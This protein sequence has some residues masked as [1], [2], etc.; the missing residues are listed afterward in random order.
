MERGILSTGVILLAVLAGCREQAAEVEVTSTREVTSSDRVP[1][2][3]ATSRE[4]FTGRAQAAG[5]G[6]DI[7]AVAGGVGTKPGFKF[8]AQE[9]WQ[10]RPGTQFRRLNFAVGADGAGE[11][12]VSQSRGGL[13]GNIGRWL[14]QFGQAGATEADVSA[15]PKVMVMGGEGILVEAAGTY[16]PG[17]GR[18][19]AEG[20]ALLGVIGMV[21]GGV[22]T[23]KMTGPEAVVKAERERFLNFCKSLRPVE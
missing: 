20:S 6:A 16:S 5:M 10:E 9:G 4:R 23:V 3:K 1:K 22:L 8:E 17:M 13:V 19:P 12:Y 18:P 15:M 14:G 2:L 21:D 11:V 7:G